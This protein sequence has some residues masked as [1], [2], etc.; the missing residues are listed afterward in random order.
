[1]CVCVR[2]YIYV[3][4]FIHVCVHVREYIYVNIFIHVCVSASNELWLR[5]YIYDEDEVVCMCMRMCI[6]TR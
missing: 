2:E 1:M 3:N 4:I 5:E 6:P